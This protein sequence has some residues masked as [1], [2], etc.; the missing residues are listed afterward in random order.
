MLLLL[1]QRESDCVTLRCFR[2]VRTLQIRA[3]VTTARVNGVRTLRVRICV[4]AARVNG[5]SE[6]GVNLINSLEGSDC[7]GQILVQSFSAIFPA[8]Y[9]CYSNEKSKF[10]YRQNIRGMKCA[11]LGIMASTMTVMAS[12]SRKAAVL[13]VMASTTTIVTLPA[14]CR[15]CHF[16]NL[17][18]SHSP[19]L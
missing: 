1:L 15:T 16:N 8:S 2:V 4:R 12:S 11:I 17:S 3:Y 14:S 6:R 5:D 13:R 9:P 19:D 7:F 10:F 18:T